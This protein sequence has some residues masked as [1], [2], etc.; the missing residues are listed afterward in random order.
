MV[1][2]YW[3]APSD[4]D[5]FLEF[6]GTTGSV[7][8]YSI[9][10]KESPEAVQPIDLFTF[11]SGSH[12]SQLMIGLADGYTVV[13]KHVFSGRIRYNVTPDQSAV[14]VYRRGLTS[15]AK[16]GRS[17]LA[18][19]YDISSRSGAADRSFHDWCTKVFGWVRKRTP[20]LDASGHYRISLAA[21]AGAENGLW[22]LSI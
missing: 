8:A 11:V 4:E 13:E 1:L 17:N 3:S 20:A 2:T 9:E 19:Y 7:V 14:I 10:W 18:A 22:E 12:P 21:K 16:L 6:L 15:E 5:D